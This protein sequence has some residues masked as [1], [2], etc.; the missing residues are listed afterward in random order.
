MNS[1]FRKAIGFVFELCLLSGCIVIR[2]T[3]AAWEEKRN[4]IE[5]D[6]P[7]SQDAV[8][9]HYEKD[10]YEQD[11][12]GRIAIGIVPG[13][14]EGFDENAE[15]SRHK[16]SAGADPFT[17]SIALMVSTFGSLFVAPF[18]E[19]EYS[20]FGLIGCHRWRSKASGRSLIKVGE[21]EDIIEKDRN[22]HCDVEDLVKMSDDM[23]LRYSYPGY[24]VVQA[25]VKKFGQVAVAFDRGPKAYRKFKKSKCVE[26]ALTY[27]DVAEGTDAAADQLIWRRRLEVATN[28]IA[29][30]MSSK[31]LSLCSESYSNRVFEIEK[32][33]ADSLNAGSFDGAFV[34]A[35]QDAIPSLR[36]LTKREFEIVTKVNQLKGLMAQKKYGDV[37]A[38]KNDDD[39][40]DDLVPYW[41]PEGY[42]LAAKNDDDADERLLALYKQAEVMREDSRVANKLNSAKNAH[43][44]GKYQEALELVAHET[45]SRFEEIRRASRDAMEKQEAAQRAEMKRQEEERRRKMEEERL[46]KE[47]ERQ[48]QEEKRKALERQFVETLKEMENKCNR[49]L[50]KSRISCV[51]DTYQAIYGQERSP[52]GIRGKLEFRTDC[53]RCNKTI[54][55]D[56]FVYVDCDMNVRY[57]DYDFRNDDKKT[58]CGD[59]G[60]WVPFDVPLKEIL[61]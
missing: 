48:A 41:L 59:C 54:K 24:G 4:P 32:E 58:K 45:D 25:D 13:F 36:E 15:Q 14:G 55:R 27:E 49:Q 52:I 34:L 5:L 19:N 2:D 50:K 21:R 33:V 22:M 1:G 17:L 6:G 3:T 16:F 28:D 60:Y 30:I 42:V 46:A 57:N 20:L 31:E 39:A 38:A 56:V 8:F 23:S 11:Y 26:N 44:N 51:S 47:K 40:D 53:P 35:K 12:G 7:G 37:L 9:S 29:K 61:K 43:D 18:C 10:K